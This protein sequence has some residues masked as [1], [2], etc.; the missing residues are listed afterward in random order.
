MADGASSWK[1]VVI[2]TELGIQF[3]CHCENRA[4]FS[5]KPAGKELLN[6]HTNIPHTWI[7]RNED[8][9]LLKIYSKHSNCKSENIWAI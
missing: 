1:G 6:Q 4:K 7:L 3:Y 8:S 9:E 2:L 5:H